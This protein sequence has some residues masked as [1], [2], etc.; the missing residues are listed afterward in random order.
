M[1]HIL[2]PHDDVSRIRFN[3]DDVALRKSVSERVHFGQDFSS[4]L[5]FEAAEYMGSGDQLHTAIVDPG[6]IQTQPEIEQYRHGIPPEP[7]NGLAS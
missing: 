6:R 5:V 2:V 3:G 7:S 1:N 4:V